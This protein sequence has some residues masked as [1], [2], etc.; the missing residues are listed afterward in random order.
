VALSRTLPNQ[1][2]RLLA[3]FPSKR[4]MMNNRSSRGK[5]RVLRLFYT[6]SACSPC[7]YCVSSYKL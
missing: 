5:R 2:S 4:R 7:V 1:V 3:H 6:K